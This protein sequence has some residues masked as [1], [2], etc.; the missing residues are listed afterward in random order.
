MN[1][2]AEQAHAE[3]DVLRMKTLL[4]GLDAFKARGLFDKSFIMWTNHV[5]DGPSHSFKNVPHII[6]GNAGGYLKQGAY[7]D[8]GNVT[9]NKLFN[10]LIAAATRDKSSAPPNFGNASGTGPIAGLL[11]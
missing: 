8:A 3:I 9:N 6:A 4:H 11:A 1:P 7:I 5:A 10:T 2:T